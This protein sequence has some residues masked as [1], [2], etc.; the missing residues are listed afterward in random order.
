MEQQLCGCEVL[1]KDQHDVGVAGQ[2][3]PSAVN[4]LPAGATVAR[5]PAWTS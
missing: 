4:P 3:R 2:A 1:R 5:I